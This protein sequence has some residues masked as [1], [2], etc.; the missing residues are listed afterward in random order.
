MKLRCETHRTVITHRIH[1]P[2]DQLQSQFLDNLKLIFTQYCQHTRTYPYTHII[3]TVCSQLKVKRTQY[4]IKLDDGFLLIDFE[5]LHIF[6]FKCAIIITS[7]IIYK[8]KP[9]GLLNILLNLLWKFKFIKLE[10][11]NIIQLIVTCLYQ[12]YYL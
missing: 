9:L 12:M 10:W 6:L 8:H 7:Y 11:S 4:N 5:M 1:W 2:V 3:Y